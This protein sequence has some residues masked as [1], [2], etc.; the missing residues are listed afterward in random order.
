[1]EIFNNIWQTM[2]LI[3]VMDIVDIF[4]VTLLLYY[5]FRF[6]KGTSVQH[7]LQGLL[8][9]F[10]ALLVSGWLKLNI[11]NY[12]LTS[13]FKIGIIALIILFQPEI[14][15]M[16]Q[17]FGSNSRFNF[18]KS[19]NESENQEI[20]L[21]IVNTVEAVKEMSKARVGALI[22]FERNDNISAVV[23]SGTHVDAAI[24]KELLENIFY[25]KSPLHDGA[26]I[27]SDGRIKAAGCILPLSANYN[28]GKDLGT[29]HRAAL[30]M[31][32]NYDSLSVVVS[33]ENS[34]ISFACDGM[35]KRHLSPET[36][37]KLLEKELL[38]EP[39]VTEKFSFVNWLK[40]K[41]NQ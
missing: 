33:E 13:V 27:I 14:R 4:I 31:S 34:S 15:K 12:L 22:V 11:I 40:G 26:V 1:M 6:A 16:L 19:S 9:L 39:V 41:E 17:Q 29:R 23:N 3:T 10:G 38:P 35:L 36:L 25:P 24:S 7:I 18:I 21:A 37:G 30:G 32:E 20:K 28:I 8:I 2:R 5:L